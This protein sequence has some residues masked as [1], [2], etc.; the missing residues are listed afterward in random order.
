MTTS[1]S[2]QLNPF[3]KAVQF[4]GNQSAL[5]RK[6]GVSRQAVCSYNRNGWFSHETAQKLAKLMR[7]PV[8][9]MEAVWTPRK[10][11]T[12]KKIRTKA[13]RAKAKKI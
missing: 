8:E 4:F 13:E 10:K 5:A 11:N 2:K 6:L 12:G 7:V 9:E 1:T 3:Q